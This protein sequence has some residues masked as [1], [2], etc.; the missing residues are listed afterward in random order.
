MTRASHH[1]SP[2]EIEREVEETRAR[3]RADLADMRGRLSPGTMVDQAIDYARQSGGAE[4]TATSAGR[5]GTIRC[6]SR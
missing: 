6:R 3:L 4:F 1:R 2:A 5:C